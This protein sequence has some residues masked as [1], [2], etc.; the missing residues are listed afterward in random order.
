MNIRPAK[1]DDAT[2][3]AR[4]AFASGLPDT[5]HLNIG[6]ATTVAEDESGVVAFCELKELPYG[7]IIEDWWCFPTH[8]GFEGLLSLGKWVETIAQTLVAARGKELMVGGVVRLDNPTHKKMLE[9][10][11]YEIEAVVLAKRFKPEI[12]GEAS[13]ELQAAGAG[14]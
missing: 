14:R 8:A 6:S 7:L 10:R 9:K 2:D 12:Q 4:I 5:W 11:G 13:A 3:I 1:A